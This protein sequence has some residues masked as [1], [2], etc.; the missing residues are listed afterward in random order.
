MAQI[1][2]NN[3]LRQAATSEEGSLAAADGRHT[4][5]S[6]HAPTVL[7]SELQAATMGGFSTGV[8]TK[9][10]GQGFKRTF[11]KRNLPSPPATAFASPEGT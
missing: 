10:T 11:Y 6:A 1:A 2:V 5:A 3:D 9:P 4:P 7:T 8:T